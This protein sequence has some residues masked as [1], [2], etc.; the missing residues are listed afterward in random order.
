MHADWV[1]DTTVCLLS[2]EYYNGFRLREIAVALSVSLCNR[3]VIS[4]TRTWQC[5]IVRAIIAAQAWVTDQLFNAL[6]QYIVHI[7]T[8]PVNFNCSTYFPLIDIHV[9]PPPRVPP[10]RLVKLWKRKSHL[11]D[12]LVLNLTCR[13]D[14]LLVNSVI[15]R[16][17]TTLYIH[18][19]IIRP[20]KKRRSP[21]K[22]FHTLSNDD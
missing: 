22:I 3:N 1:I 13:S 11:R 9:S 5:N 16:L 2:W 18:P 20:R 6:L 14:K 10:T 4:H 8:R 19:D 7:Y 17:R 15:L 21:P 12:K